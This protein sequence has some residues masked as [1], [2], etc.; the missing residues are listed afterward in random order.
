M[1][2]IKKQKAKSYFSW[3]KWVILLGRENHPIIEGNSTPT[4]VYSPL[5]KNNL[6]PEKHLSFSPPSM[7]THKPRFCCACQ[8]AYPNLPDVRFCAFCAA[9]VP[10]VTIF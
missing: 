8:E 5:G 9:P 10:E 2:T 7:N 1:S 3:K 6:H 4:G